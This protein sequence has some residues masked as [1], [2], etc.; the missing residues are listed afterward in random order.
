MSATPV[1]LGPVEGARLLG[2]VLVPLVAQGA[3]VR[4]PRA[5][6]WAERHQ[7]DRR[8]AAVLDGLRSRYG[9]A[10]LV[11]RLGPRRLVFVTRPDD[12]AR[13]LEGT[14]EPFSPATRE[15]RG[16]LGHF[17][18]EGS[19]LG[20][21]AERRQRRPL[22]ERALQTGQAVHDD[23]AAI[24]AVVRR[25]ANAL[26]EEVRARGRLDAPTFAA[27]FWRAVRTV[28]FGDAA[29]GD[30]ALSAELEAL[31]HDANWS[32]FRP[33]RRRRRAAFLERVARY[34]E[35]APPG[36][37]AAAG[38]GRAVT[39]QV[40]QWLFAFDAVA[41]TVLRA[42]AV[43]G[44]RPEVRQAVL[45]ELADAGEAPA[46]LPYARACVL[47]AVRLWPTTLVVLRDSTAPTDWGGRTL[48][49]G[50]GFAIV[51]GWAH[52]DRTRIDFADA[53]TPE[54][55]LDGRAQ[56]DRALVPFS[57][58]PA[59]CAGRDV[60]LFVA[61][62][63]LARLAVLDLVPDRGRYLAA[64]PLPATVDHLGL[65]FRP[66]RDAAPGAVDGAAP[67]AVEDAAPG[68]VDDP[69]PDGGSTVR[70][71]YSRE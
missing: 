7:A 3:I 44:A 63:L 32:Y 23:A 17:E 56:A 33:V 36:T 65:R 51:S 46:E 43:V 62:H 45:R 58:G 24:L 21:A 68:A 53:F 13:L 41:A 29:R 30:T 20:S 25:E 31:R 9:G 1:D 22:N 28:V 49:A 70:A 4:R 35:Q 27:P 71:A 34:A 59:V 67:G 50:T 47:E 2:Q 19:L 54:A 61:S 42:L 40:P 15:K 64:D 5:T 55:W 69:A 16:A 37:L 10:P 14:P 52:R 18:P 8:A 66:R 26:A 48:P 6:A 12:V 60:V 39:G 57:A 38:G 11:L